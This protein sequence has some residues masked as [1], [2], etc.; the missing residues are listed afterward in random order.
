MGHAAF[1]LGVLFEFV[2]NNDGRCAIFAF[3]CVFTLEF[4]HNLH[5]QLVHGVT[6]LKQRHR[7]VAQVEDVVQL[8]HTSSLARVVD[9]RLLLLIVRRGSVGFSPKGS[10]VGLQCGSDR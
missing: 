1:F 3:V 2:A 4:E 10:E 5:L 9:L 7:R 6:C 8:Q